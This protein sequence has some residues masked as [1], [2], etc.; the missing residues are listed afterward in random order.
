MTYALL[1]PTGVAGWSETLQH[2]EKYRSPKYTRLTTGQFYASRIMVRDLKNP[3]PHRAGLLFQQYLV[4]AYCRT[5][6]QRLH[7]LRTHQSELRAEVYQELKSTVRGPD[8]VPGATT[9]GRRIVL[10]ASYPGSP[11]HMQQNYLDA[12]AMVRVLGKPDFLI[13]FTANPAWPEITSSLLPGQSP[14]DR[15]DIVARVFNIKLRELM[16]DLTKRGALGKAL[17]WTWVVE[18]QKRGLPHAHILLIVAPEDKPRSPEDVDSRVCA[19]LPDPDDPDKADLLDIISKSQLHGPCGPRNPSRVCMEDGKCTKGFPKSFQEKTTMP[20]TVYPL[21][22]RRDS[23]RTI[24]KNGHI[25]DNRD[26]V[27]YNPGL[28]KKYRAHINIEVVSTIKAVKYLY[29]YCYKGHDRATLEVGVDEIQDKCGCT[30]C[31]SC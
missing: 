19:E 10:P 12:M 8:F 30:L 1:F 21:Y 25:M 9:V 17:G 5:E 23:G 13:T 27:G 29:K 4:D 14:H 20:P 2:E 24:E 16:E 11:R 28:S 26:V 3:L 7:Y 15:P 22:R 31:G 6:G 18:F